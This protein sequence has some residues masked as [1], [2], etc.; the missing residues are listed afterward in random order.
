MTK[1]IIGFIC[2]TYPHQGVREI[3]QAFQDISDVIDG[4]QVAMHAVIGNHYL[5]VRDDN[6][7]SAD[8]IQKIQL[9]AATLNQV[10]NEKIK[11]TLIAHARGC[12]SSLRLIKKINTDR[13]LKSCIDIILDFRDPV[14]GDL[15]DGTHQALAIA[16][17]LKDFSECDN[18]VEANITVFER[19]LINVG[20]NVLIPRFHPKTIVEVEYLPG[21]H[22]IQQHKIKQNVMRS[23]VCVRNEILYSLAVCKS[24]HILK[25]NGIPLHF[26]ETDYVTM[27]AQLYSILLYRYKEADTL[28]P[29]QRDVYFGGKFKQLHDVQSATVLN[30]RHWRLSPELDDKPLL[31][32]TGKRFDILFGMH[33][34]ALTPKQS[35]MHALR[36]YLHERHDEFVHD[37][38]HYHSFWG[39]LKGMSHEVKTTAVVRLLERLESDTDIVN[40]AALESKKDRKALQEGRLQ[41]LIHKYIE[42]GCLEFRP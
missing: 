20:Y 8:L 40:L 4:G 6:P 23:G 33:D 1:Y 38:S 2:D 39:R 15:N 10:E 3:D 41:E 36:L 27:Q 42:K 7:A 26:M 21:I 29:H 13:A 5:S 24:L 30:A 32:F 17:Q 9:A 11:L 16:N 25:A 12:V 31:G 22:D 14:T 19:A 18:V 34:E 28:I 37:H 35:L